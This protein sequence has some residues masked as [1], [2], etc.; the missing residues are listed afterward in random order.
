MCTHQQRYFSPLQQVSNNT[1][2]NDFGLSYRTRQSLFLATFALKT[3]SGLLKIGLNDSCV[4]NMSSFQKVRTIS[5][6]KIAQVV[7]LG[8]N[9]IRADDKLLVWVKIQKCH[10]HQS[11]SA[12]CANCLRSH[13]LFRIFLPVYTLKKIVKYTLKKKTFYQAQECLES[14]C[15]FINSKPL[16]M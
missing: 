13:A 10:I 15:Y 5:R 7:N 12:I 9:C 3:I 8:E 11:N 16:K 1:T 14:R 4:K 6:C 2:V